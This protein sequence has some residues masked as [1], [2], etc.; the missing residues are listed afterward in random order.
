LVHL[1]A[2]IRNYRQAVDLWSPSPKGKPKTT[3]LEPKEPAK[4]GA[5]AD[6]ALA[7]RAMLGLAWMLEEASNLREAFAKGVES[8]EFAKLDKADR[9]AIEKLAA[10]SKDWQA[11]SLEAYRGV[12]KLMAE[13]DKRRGFSGPEA[14]TLMSGDAAAGIVRV[15]ESRKTDFEE[16][17]EIASMKALLRQLETVGK[18]VTPIIFPARS[19]QPL[20]RLVDSQKLVDFDLAA[21]GIPR[22][23][24]WL[25]GD[26]CLLVWDPGRTGAVRDGKQLFGSVT[27]WIFWDDGYQPLAALDNDG[28]G[29]LSGKELAGL[30]V[31]QDRN[32]NG[33]SEAGEVVTVERHGIRRIATAAQGREQ[34]VLSNPRGIELNSGAWLPT[35][36]WTPTAAPK[37]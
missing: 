21:D 8:G 24:P 11:Q 35:Y 10:G 9:A 18:T 23:W 34:G 6:P 3:D 36:D 27:W 1:E 14:D 31:W 16:R 20:D 4:G 12:V 37:R 33:R 25:R 15:L 32:G 7:A 26:T 30:A 2:S 19:P 17:E 22:K 13:K 5:K 28:D 29:W